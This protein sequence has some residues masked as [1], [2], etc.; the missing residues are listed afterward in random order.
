LGEFGDDLEGETPSHLYHYYRDSTFKPTDERSDIVI[1]SYVLPAEINLGYTGLGQRVVSKFNGMKIRSV[2]DIVEAQKLNPESKFDVI[3]FE[4][5]SP[6]IVI[7][8]EKL[9]EADTFVSRN[10]GIEKLS[11]INQ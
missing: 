6:M 9:A 3:E 8:R 4:M 5:D 11:N 2:A 7:S 1:L 10:Y